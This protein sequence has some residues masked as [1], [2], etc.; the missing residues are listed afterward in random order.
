[1]DVEEILGNF[2]V[3]SQ[4]MSQ[5]RCLLYTLPEAVVCIDVKAGKLRNFNGLSEYVTCVMLI[6][7]AYYPSDNIFIGFC[8]VYS[9]QR[10]L[11]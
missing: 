7:A 5:V 9:G 4:I 3:L 2:T 8:E 1:M 10:C 6:G 11:F